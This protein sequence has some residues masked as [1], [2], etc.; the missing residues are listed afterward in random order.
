MP[1][2]TSFP[3]YYTP[4]TTSS[5]VVNLLNTFTYGLSTSGIALV[6]PIQPHDLRSGFLPPSPRPTGVFLGDPP[7]PKGLI[8]GIVY[9]AEEPP[10]GPNTW[11]NLSAL[12]FNYVTI[13]PLDT[14]P[15]EGWSR[16]HLDLSGSATAF[17]TADL[18]VNITGELYHSDLGSFLRVDLTD[19]KVLS[20]Y[21]YGLH[22]YVDLAA[23]VICKP[24][25]ALFQIHSKD[26]FTYAAT[27]EGLVVFHNDSTDI[28]V[29]REL[30]YDGNYNIAT[31]I[32]GSDTTLY[33]GTEN[34][35]WYIKFTDLHNDFDTSTINKL[36]TLQSENIKYIHGDAEDLLIS[37]T[38]GIEYIKNLGEHT[39]IYLENSRKCFLAGTSGYYISQKTENDNTQD[40]LNR[41]DNMMFDWTSPAYEYISGGTIFVE[42]LQL[43]DMYI[44][45]DTAEDGGNTIFCTTSSGVYVIDED[46]QKYAIY[47]TAEVPTGVDVFPYTFPFILG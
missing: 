31:T 41:I 1:T 45:K 18:S 8:P 20:S 12:G 25:Y 2:F 28:I 34:G 16:Y 46:I 14:P 37:T 26:D 30:S 22:R 5:G 11:D 15:E 10:P 6:R 47:Y 35:L 4:S 42:N 17:Y 32:W 33:I 23:D 7:T 19:T 29:T 21:I 43:T 3:L 13:L 27:T 9:I 38:S 39:K 24:P 36:N 40:V 44:T